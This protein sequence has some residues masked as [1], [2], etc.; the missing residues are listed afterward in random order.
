MQK[1]IM[2]LNRVKWE[3]RLTTISWKW[4]LLGSSALVR[5]REHA[6]SWASSEAFNFAIRKAFEWDDKCRKFL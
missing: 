2:K 6:W 4:R 3:W 1:R 5:A